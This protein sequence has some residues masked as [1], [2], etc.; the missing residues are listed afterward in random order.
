MES[1]HLMKENN[2]LDLRPARYSDQ[3][4]DAGSHVKTNEEVYA[5]TDMCG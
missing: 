5:N 3:V 4:L 1:A 2:W